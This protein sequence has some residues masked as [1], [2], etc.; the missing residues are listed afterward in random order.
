MAFVLC[1]STFSDCE[2]V[3]GKQEDSL[4]PAGPLRGLSFVYD[5]SFSIYIPLKNESAFGEHYG[6]P[7]VY[8]P[9]SRM[10]RGSDFFSF[11][12]CV[13]VCGGGVK[14]LGCACQETCLC[15]HV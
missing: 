8:G 13:C 6:F 1:L 14:R 5:W 10:P 4:I 9:P 3:T 15:V 11:F 12:L 7:V 2:Q